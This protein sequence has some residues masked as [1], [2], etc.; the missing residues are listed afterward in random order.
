MLSS[1]SVAHVKGND[2][3]AGI[4]SYLTGHLVKDACDHAIAHGDNHMAFLISEA[5]GSEDVRHLML[6][7]LAVWSDI[8]VMIIIINSNI[9]YWTKRPT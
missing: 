1:I 2:G 4:F 8:Q 3:A 6:K 7:Q 9:N 5:F